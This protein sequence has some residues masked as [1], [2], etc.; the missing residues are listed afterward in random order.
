[1]SNVDMFENPSHAKDRTFKSI[2][3][4]SGELYTLNR[5]FHD[6]KVELIPLGN[7]SDEFEEEFDE[8]ES[9]ERVENTLIV[10]LNDLNFEVPKLGYL[11]SVS[12]RK[13]HS[14]FSYLNPER[15]WKTGLILNYI[16]FKTSSY[17]SLNNNNRY[18]S[19]DFAK[20][21]SYFSFRNLILNRF[22]SYKLVVNW[23]FNG[24]KTPYTENDKKFLKEFGK[25]EPISLCFSKDFSITRS[26]DLLFRD[27]CVGNI[28]EDSL[29]LLDRFKYLSKF[30]E[31]IIHGNG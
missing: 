30:L 17:F 8:D 26:G 9:V 27:V 16:R 14:T 4:L 11:T 2:H 12:N 28:K 24:D 18:D 25:F 15:N 1:M 3:L 10:H 19:E 21:I 5:V 6:Y 22:P 20:C 7:L 29:I 31:K 13:I 23:M